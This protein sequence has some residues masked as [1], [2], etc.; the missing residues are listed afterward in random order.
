MLRPSNLSTVERQLVAE[1]SLEHKAW[2][3][4]N[5]VLN[6]CVSPSYSEVGDPLALDPYVHVFSFTVDSFLL[7]VTLFVWSH[8]L[9]VKH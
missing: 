9:I 8:S 6:Y 2:N 4:R 7:G 5:R 3:S 1:P